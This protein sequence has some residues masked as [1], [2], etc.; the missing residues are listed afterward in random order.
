MPVTYESL[1]TTTLGTAA[2]TI[3]FNSIS[4]AYTDLRVVIVEIGVTAADVLIRFNSS[5]TGYSATRMRGNGTNVTVQNDLSA[6]YLRFDNVGSSTTV[7][8]LKTADIF[9]Y[10]NSSNYKSVLLISNWDVAGGTSSNGVYYTVGAWANNSA[11]TSVNILRAS[12]NFNV[13]T[14]A[15]LYGIK[16]A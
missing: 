3:D 6:S 15:T 9:S 2:A 10:S 14:T 1:A 7:P 12:G 5:S 11:I 16:A 13:G 4:S 8:T